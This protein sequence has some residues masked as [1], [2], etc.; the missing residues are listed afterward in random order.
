MLPKWP[1]FIWIRLQG[2]DYIRFI[3]FLLL[4]FMYKCNVRTEHEMNMNNKRTKNEWILNYYFQSHFDLVGA[5]NTQKKSRSYL[6]DIVQPY[7]PPLSVGSL[8][9]LT[10]LLKKTG[11]ICLLR[12]KVNCFSFSSS[13]L[14]TK[15]LQSTILQ[16]PSSE[17]V[18]LTRDSFVLIW[19]TSVRKVYIHV[20]AAFN[21]T[22]FSLCH[23]CIFIMKNK[24][25]HFS[26][27]SLNV[28]VWGN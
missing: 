16:A 9:I 5:I 11:S 22:H 10:W 7:L 17:K 20:Q 15:T 6:S 3:F 24:W 14:K 2:V 12:F 23:Y 26:S 19:G 21:K 27:S 4:L 28:T 25:T 8:W 18:G 13:K 1:P